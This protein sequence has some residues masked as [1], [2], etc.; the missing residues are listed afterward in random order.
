MRRVTGAATLLALLWSSAPA[1]ADATAQARQHFDRGLELVDDGQYSEAIVEFG[2]CYELK[3]HYAVFYNIGQ[4]YIALA[5]PVEAAAALRRYLDEGGKAIDAK[6]KAAVQKEIQRQE[7]R[8]ATLDIRVLPAGATV[9][10]DGTELG[11][12]PLSAPVSVGV[13][14]H[15]VTASLMGYEPGEA[16]ATVAGGDHGS[17]ELSLAPLARPGAGFAAPP[18]PPPLAAGAPAA[19]QSTEPMP[20]APV[21]AV[22][23]VPDTG[24]SGSTMRTVGVVLAAT[25]VAGLGA[26]ATCWFV[27]SSKHEDALSEHQLGNIASAHRLQSQ[28]EQLVP[29][30][31]IGFIGGGLL[32]AAGTVLYLTAPPGRPRRSGYDGAVWPLVAADSIGLAT[33]GTF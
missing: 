31:N 22:P 24:S 4:A 13:G 30:V 18:P 10:L 2:R 16:T 32:A 15:T 8:I 33:K 25:G 20:A 11:R 28:S 19:P 17:V 14:T 26:G 5:K 7:A 21:P 29:Y 23:P 3:P 6:R 1:Y 12:S 9:R 27:A